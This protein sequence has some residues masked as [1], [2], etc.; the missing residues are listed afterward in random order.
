MERMRY[1]HSVTML[2]AL[3]LAFVFAGAF[4]ISPVSADETPDGLHI[5]ADSV[6]YQ[7]NTGKAVADGS[8]KVRS[9]S[10]RLF[11]PRVE[12]SSNNQLLEA[13][14]DE[15]GKVTLRSG[16]GNTTGDHLTYSV[17]TRKGILKSAA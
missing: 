3:L 17:E 2:R 4:L 13:F 8:V 10:L 5:D 16:P 14:S 12:Y 6:V 11:A 1:R 9:K 15:R 7:E